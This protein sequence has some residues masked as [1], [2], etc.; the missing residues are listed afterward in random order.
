MSGSTTSYGPTESS[1]LV[2]SSHS[3]RAAR[4]VH[5]LHFLFESSSPP[6]NLLRATGSPPN[7]LRP[8][9]RH[10]DHP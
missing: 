4:N 2:V 7:L 5:P 6:P 3:Q 9:I 8:L 10:P 1:D